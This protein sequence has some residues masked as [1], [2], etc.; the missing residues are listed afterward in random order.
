MS[1]NPHTSPLAVALFEAFARNGGNRPNDH[2]DRNAAE[3]WMQQALDECLPKPAAAQEAVRQPDGYH[4]RY[5]DLYG[6]DTCIR[7]N[8]GEEV[9]G[10]KPVEAVPYWYAPVTA[11]PAD[12]W[13]ADQLTAMGEVIPLASTP[14]APADDEEDAYVIDQMGKLLAEIAVIVNG[15]EPAGTRWSYH[16]LPAKVKALASTPAAPGIG[17]QAFRK[18]AMPLLCQM[19]CSHDAE[20]VARKLHA[21]LLDASPKGAL[22][23]QFGS[24]EGLGGSEAVSG[25]GTCG[26]SLAKARDA[27]MASDEA[28]MLAN[29]RNG[30]I[31][32]KYLRNRLEVAFCAGYDAA[33]AGDAEVQP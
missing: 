14:A 22:N 5:P 6:T 1:A 10:S 18:V 4:Y 23:E 21:A 19:L 16:D 13:F 29:D 33:Q 28:R 26:R 15:P 2:F 11:A 25:G 17:L 12:T 27:W 20:S 24:A 3:Q 7:K 30:P 8:N 31:A 32:G 9:N